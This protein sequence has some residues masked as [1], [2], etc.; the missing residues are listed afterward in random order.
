[1][2]KILFLFI[3]MYIYVLVYVY[4]YVCI[5]VPICIC[6][7]GMYGI[8]MVMSPG[9]SF[10]RSHCMLHIH[11][12]QL[13]SMWNLSTL[14]FCCKI[15]KLMWKSSVRWLLFFPLQDPCRPGVKDAVSLCKNAGVKVNCV[16]ISLTF[17]D[18][19]LINCSSGF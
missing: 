6:M 19:Q 17:I 11:V 3:Y 14:R 2:L 15:L 7:L 18:F 16:P 13:H 5:I 12:K 1:M 8:W 4:M 9:P 10:L